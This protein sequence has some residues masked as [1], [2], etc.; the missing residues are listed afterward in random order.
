M[1]ENDQEGLHTMNLPNFENGEYARFRMAT[2][3]VVAKV[4]GVRGLPFLDGWPDIAEGWDA[5]DAHK[6]GGRPLS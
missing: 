6:R 4:L 3:K 1:R 2:S 5:L